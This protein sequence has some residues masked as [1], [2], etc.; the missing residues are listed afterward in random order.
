[1]ALSPSLKTKDSDHASHSSLR[2]HRAPPSPRLL[3]SPQHSYDGGS[4]SDEFFESLT[5]SLKKHKTGQ[6]VKALLEDECVIRPPNLSKGKSKEKERQLLSEQEK[7]H[8]YEEALYTVQYLLGASPP[9]YMADMRQLIDYLQQAFEMTITKHENVMLRVKQAIAPVPMLAVNVVKARD[10]LPKDADG[11]SDPYCMLGIVPVQEEAAA[12]E[13]RK[14]RRFSFRRRR[15]TRNEKRGSRET[16]PAKYI[17]CT[18]VKPHTLNPVWNEHFRLEIDDIHKD[19][20]HLD[21]WDHD[22]DVS[23][24]EACR[25][26]NEVNSLKGMGR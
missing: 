15:E 25:K 7:E 26:L 17:Q 21:I 9:G 2:R 4:G 19:V 1:M 11:F 14:E 18:E 6:Y 22:D 12:A 20:L 10:L 16:L 8:L 5:L 13:G 24:A 3:H 23:V